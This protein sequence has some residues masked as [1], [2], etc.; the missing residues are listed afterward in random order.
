MLHIKMERSRYLI[1]YLLH[2]KT[3]TP[4]T[5]PQTPPPL[6]LMATAKTQTVVKLDQREHVLKRPNLY[7]GSITPDTISAWVLNEDSTRMVKRDVSFIPGLYKIFDEVV[8]NAIDHVTRMK[9]TNGTPVKK[10]DITISKETGEISVLNDG[11]GLSVDIHEET[12]VYIPELIMGHLL[13]STNYD[14]SEERIIGGMN[15][16][17]AKLTNIYSTKF[18]VETVDANNQKIYKQVFTD[19]LSVTNKPI[20]KACKKV[21]YTKITFV[22]DYKAFKCSGLTEDMY[23]IL[24]KRVYDVAALTPPEVKV[25]FNGERVSCKGFEDYANLYLGTKIEHKRTY[26]AL[27]PRWEVTLSTSDTGTFECVSFVNGIWTLR[28]GKHVDHVM[29]QVIKKIT[30]T[31]QKKKKDI[32]IKPQAIRDN[33]MLFINATIVNPSFDNQSKETLTSP[34]SAFGSK[35]DVSD[36]FITKFLTAD[37][38]ERFLAAGNNE[39]EKLLKKTD[40][41]KRD[42]VRGIAKLDDANWAGGPR[43][44]ECTLIL[45]EGDSAKSLAISGL[46]VVGRD[47]YGVFPLRGKLLNVKDATDTKISGN[48]EITALKK[49]LGLESRKTY[50]DL[51]QLRYGHIMALCDSDV[52]GFH[53]KGLLFNIFQ[54]MWPSLLKMNG[55]MLSM[56]TPIV[57]ATKGKTVKSFYTMTDYNNWYASEESNGGRGWE[58][59][60]YKGLGT[61]TDKE[62]KEYF[63][64][65]KRIEY[66]WTGNES[67]ASLDLAFNKKRADDRKDWIGGYDKQEVLDYTNPSVAYEDF[68]NKELIHFSVD[69]LERSIPSMCDGFKRTIRKILYCCFKRNLVK[70]IRVAQLAGYV[71]ENGA[72]HHGEASLQ[73]AIIGMAATYVG[74]NNINLLQ[75]NGQFG[76]RLNGGSDSASPR[77]IHTELNPIV[78]AVYPKSDLAILDYTED[79]GQKVEPVHYLPIIPMVLVNGISGI[80]TGFST[81]IPAHNPLDVVACIKTLLDNVGE[82]AIIA[83]PEIK[84]WYNGFIGDIEADDNNRG[85]ISKGNYTRLTANSVE[86]TEL[87][88]GTW[89]SDFKELLEDMIAK[90]TTRILRDYESHYTARTIK[91]IL[92]FIPGV[93]DGLLTERDKNGY[94]AFENLFKMH[95]TKGLSTSNMHLYDEN[96]QIRLFDSVHSIIRSY[97]GVRWNGYI[98]RKQ[99]LILKLEDETMIL[100]AKVRFILEII[101]GTLIVQNIKKADVD[102]N[103]E[104]S[105]YPTQ[106]DS[107]DYLTRMPISSLTLEKKEEWVKEAE[108]RLIELERVKAMTIRE[109]WAEDLIVFEKAYETYLKARI[110]EEQEDASD[111][112]ASKSAKKSRGSA[113]AKKK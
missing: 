109:M 66:Q 49:I 89:T 68:I 112:V 21:P 35:C 70:E 56:L 50:T 71:S 84:P 18:D 69:N 45:T 29:N 57:K 2:K 97:F 25:T 103:L 26:E 96:G 54:S 28:G 65:M 15:G 110:I 5:P 63:R 14:D 95:S 61:S 46:S 55:F 81:T 4:Q 92:H 59:K 87:P 13:T 99:A 30:E 111:T 53:I 41:K 107:Y 24:K 86:I 101:E 106:N 6:S 94:L 102:A 39:S 60:Y 22:P 40:G 27:H 32:V 11:D 23:A 36:K 38:M 85:F 7:I 51:S 20:I 3:P 1:L 10:I 42:T 33:V 88:I 34:M 90:E 93:L 8:V 9:E 31:V 83:M 67:E 47:A 52:D 19:N 108:Q 105:E 73:D 113:A 44:S 76:S 43:S 37:V 100:N 16:M 78:W 82:Y 17:G 98:R 62:A 80:G 64:E 91:F 12:N 104:E 79:D 77:Y 58:I 48:E 74:A 72:Y 75:P